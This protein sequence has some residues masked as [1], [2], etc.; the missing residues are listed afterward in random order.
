MRALLAA[1]ALATAYPG[2]WATFRAR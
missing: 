1:L 2:A